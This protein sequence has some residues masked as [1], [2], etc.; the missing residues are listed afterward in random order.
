MVQEGRT[1]GSTREAGDPAVLMGSA[2]AGLSL[3]EIPWAC[4]SPMF[5]MAGAG[6]CSTGHVC[7]SPPEP[8]G[9]AT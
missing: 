5:K 6:G 3:Q 2:G 7:P 4:G 9:I 8:L 1:D